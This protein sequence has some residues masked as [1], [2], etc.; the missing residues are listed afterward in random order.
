MSPA[1]VSLALTMP[2]SGARG[3]TATE[4]AHVL[5]LT[6]TPETVLPA[7]GE[8]LNRMN[9]PKRTAY[10][11]FPSARRG[12]RPRPAAPTTRSCSWCVT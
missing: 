8:Q 9:D 6:G 1:S 2:W 4:M 7:V 12:P 3:A 11:P 5:H 10:T